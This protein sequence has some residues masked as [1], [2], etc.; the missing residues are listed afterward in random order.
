VR[1]GQ[2]ATGRVITAA[3]TIMILVFGS[4]LLE[5]QRV[6]AEFGVGLASAVFLDAFVLRTVLV[7]AV[8]HIL[9]ARNWWL[10]RP[11]ERALPRVAVE[12]AES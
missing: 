7:P 9:G 8:M 2:A 11:L 1:I 4:F 12:G 10:P 5:G 6:I 3:A